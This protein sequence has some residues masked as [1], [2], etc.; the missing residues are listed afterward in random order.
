MRR[1]FPA[2][3]PDLDVDL[4][5]AYWV[6]DPG[7][8]YVSTV[9]ISSADGAAQ[10]DGRSGGLGNAA[11]KRL[12]ALLRAQAEVILVGAGTARIE[13]YGG[14]HPTAE[15]RALRQR[16]GLPA[17]P[18][19]AV[20]TNRAALEPSGPLF[21]DTEVRPLVITSA[22]APADA[23]S[24]LAECADIVVAGADAVDPAVALDALRDRGLRRVSCEGGPNLLAQLIACGRLDE[25]S[26]TI[27]P[28]LLAGAARRI[29]DGPE[30]AAPV[31]LGLMHILEDGDH[32]FVRYRVTPH[33]SAA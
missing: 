2:V 6:E 13:G 10:A 23:V 19:I 7:D 3:E 4:D 31:T 29:T 18:R 27:A 12:F 30:L 33:G 20:V 17:V 14:E 24:A 1:L 5:A 11:D 9:M 16:H 15:M 32:L 26:L 28:T 25:M 21:T 22:A 8:Q